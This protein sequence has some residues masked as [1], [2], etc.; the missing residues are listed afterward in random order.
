MR[1]LIALLMAVSLGGCASVRVN[2]GHCPHFWVDPSLHA[3]SERQADFSLTRGRAG[4]AEVGAIVEEVY[5]IFGC[6]NISLVAQVGEGSFLGT[7][8][9][10]RLPSATVSPALVIQF[11]EGGSQCPGFRVVGVEVRDPR[12]RTP[13]GVG[14]GSTLGELRQRY[15]VGRLIQGEEGA[16]NAEVAALEMSFDFG[17]P[18]TDAS[19]VTGVFLHPDPDWVR[20]RKCPSGG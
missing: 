9:E 2:G 8:L 10:I 19:K 6:Q 4:P 20:L 12:F 11:R 18:F 15:Q 1:T 16:Y 5:E 3:R 7:A 14:V 13:E 17:G